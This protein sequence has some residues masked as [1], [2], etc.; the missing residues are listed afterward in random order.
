MLPRVL[1]RRLKLIAKQFP[2]VVLTGPRQSGKTTLARTTF[3]RFA[4][5]SLEDTQTREE[6]LED[7][8]G[9]LRRFEGARGVILDEIQRAPELLSTLQGVIDDRRAGPFI[10]SGS[11]QILLSGHVS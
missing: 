7:P 1:S 5:L 6:A 2:A 10:L 3:P 9:F 11:Q 4:Y 8:R